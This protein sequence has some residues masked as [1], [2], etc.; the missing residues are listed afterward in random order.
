MTE[1][2]VPPKYAEIMPYMTPISTEIADVKR[3]MSNAHLRPA[4]S[5]E[6]RSRF[7]SSVPKSPETEPVTTT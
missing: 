4:T 2:T 3:P 6:N 5:P 1:S 7:E